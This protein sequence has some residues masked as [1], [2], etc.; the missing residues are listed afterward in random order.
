VVNVHIAYPLLRFPLRFKKLFGNNVVITEHWSAYHSGF[1][2]PKEGKAK[3]RIAQIFAHGI[4]VIAVSRALMEDIVRFAGRA[5]FPKH[6]IPNVVDPD[7]FYPDAHILGGD[8]PV[9]L[10]VGNW[11]AIKRPL[12]ILEAFSEL[13]GE[14]PE[15]Q[16]RV[17]GYG[18][19]WEAMT[20]FV[21]QRGLE[22]ATAF[23]HASDYETFSV[24][25][26]E[27]LCCGTPVIA[28]DVGAIPELLEDGNGV[29]VKNTSTDWHAAL[30]NLLRNP[31]HRPRLSISTRA[32][33]HFSPAQV[34]E[35][36]REVLEISCQAN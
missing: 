35:Q 26:A 2:L 19:Q 1:N 20:G 6:V 23:L 34:G 7:I 36:L 32:K 14:F 25:C 13:L 30:R 28:S 9:F 4:P 15:A 31:S 33:R 24:V 27:A 8:A 10:M 5:D 17:A 12:L 3:A 22:S 11:A 16:L 29:L 18:T 21:E